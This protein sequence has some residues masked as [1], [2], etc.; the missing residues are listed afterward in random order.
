MS[1]SN[2]ERGIEESTLSATNSLVTCISFVLDPRKLQVVVE[3]AVHF[4]CFAEETAKLV[5]EEGERVVFVCFS[6]GTYFPLVSF[7]FKA[8]YS[9]CTQLFL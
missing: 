2:G 8:D 9:K 6:Y 1:N 3:S 5:L 4:A 7:P